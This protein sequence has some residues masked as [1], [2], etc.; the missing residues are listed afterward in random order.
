MKRRNSTSGR[1][2]ALVT[3][4]AIALATGCT[5]SGSTPASRPPAGY[6]IPAGENVTGAIS[7]L[8][9]DEAEA[10]RYTRT[11]DML[12]GRVPGLRVGRS[13]RGE[14]TLEIRG[15]GTIF[16][17][18]LLVIDGATIHTGNIG[19]ALAAVHPRDVVR[20]DVLKDATSAAVYGVRGGNGVI[21]ITTR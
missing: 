10:T 20:I 5:G 9:F 13:W 11:A 8:A 2:V 19:S 15:V 3:R 17:E 7:S 4:S 16:G 14:I 1:M 21:I 6:G 12:E 18:P